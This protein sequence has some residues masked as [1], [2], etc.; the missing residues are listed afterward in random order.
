MDTAQPFA[1]AETDPNAQIENAASAFKAFTS[2]E[3]VDKP[4][5]ELGRFAPAEAEVEAEP[6]PEDAL[7]AEA[8]PEAATEDEQ[9]AA[10]E[11]AQ[12]MPPSW[13]ADK[14]DVWA[15][16]PAD[17][18]AYLAER[19][20]EQTRA[21]QTKFQESANARKAAEAELQE[22]AN[23]RQ[24]YAELVDT[25]MAA[26]QPVA[27][28][29]RAYGAGTG[30]YNREA[31]DLAVAEY[32]E[33]MQVVQQL[34]Q[35]REALKSEA[36]REEAARFAAWKRDLEAEWAP[37]FIA[38]VP[39]LTDPVRADGTLR[40]IVDYAVRNGI[41]A[42][43]FAEDRQDAIT[44]PELHLLWKA[45]KYD[46]LKAKGAQ[47]K[48]KPPAPAVK[49]GVSSPRSAQRYAQVSRDR[50]RLAREGSIEAGAAMFKHFLKG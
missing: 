11:P 13:P 19:D 21:L 25:M 30:Q 15:T 37:K 36:E 12:P 24:R 42:D 28:D 40:S 1:A 47:P 5:D 45:M 18:Q 27:P 2:G 33:Q 17:T 49:P 46:E 26:I 23:S 35:Q 44:S 8:E 7:E 14:A 29:P 20:A 9:E 3:P 50:E 6:E 16:L 41:P 38:D 22:A 43:T 32:N 48:P 39:E 34:T 4:R 10:D 31:Y